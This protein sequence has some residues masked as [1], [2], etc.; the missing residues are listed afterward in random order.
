MK[1]IVL[2]PTIGLPIPSVKGGAVETLITDLID[3]NEKHKQYKFLVVS[4][5]CE[6]IEAIQ[7]NYK[8]TKFVV[9]RERFY[10]KFFL[11]AYRAVNKLTREK[12]AP[13]F[14]SSQNYRA[15]QKL[16]T[17]KFDYLVCE[18]GYYRNF[19]DIAKTFGREKMICHLHS[20][21][22]P[23]DYI[24]KTFSSYIA[25][26]QFIKDRWDARLH[27]PDTPTYVLRNCINIKR[28][29][30][31]KDSVDVRAKYNIPRDAYLIAYVG[32]IIPIKGVEQLINAFLK[33]H[34]PNKHLMLIGSTNFGGSEISD[35][36]RSV[37]EK[38]EK[39]IDNITITGFIPNDYLSAYLSSAN[40]VVMPS[41]CQEGAGL[42]AVETLATGV[43]LLA[44]VS[45]GIQ[46]FA[47]DGY[48]YKISKDEYFKHK[49][50]TDI[51][52]NHVLSTN[53]G[54]FEEKL[55][56]MLDNIA[57]GVIPKPKSA[58]EYIHEYDS[59][60]YYKN[61]D[62]IIREIDNGRKK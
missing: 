29:L 52:D 11:F 43:D 37:Q 48:C 40:L 1:T 2:F 39:Y 14:L 55:S 49:I 7:A 51:D 35:Y 62:K 5:W 30:A 42:V 25:I 41:L 16:K 28:F 58:L 44:T 31:N 20:E 12:V 47:R 53:W 13:L 57:L 22:V 9:V 18:G 8:Y 27:K 33:C 6:G 61:F 19:Y 38:V 46:E 59:M 23:G 15:F 34:V 36:E 21:F 56:S 32:R 10:D 24:R 26:S 50:T 4:G 17:K 54:A 3:E 60:Q 45:G